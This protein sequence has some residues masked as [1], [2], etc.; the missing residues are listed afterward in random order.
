MAGIFKARPPTPTP[1]AA[2]PDPFRTQEE[3]GAKARRD[4]LARA[5]RG[6]T[7]LTPR[8]R[9]SEEGTPSYD[10]FSSKTLSG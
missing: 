7:I 4:V 2:M 3:A 8:K 10:S 9:R 6:S 1:P 5:G